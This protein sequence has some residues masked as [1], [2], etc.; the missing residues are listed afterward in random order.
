MKT[1]TASR[2]LEQLNK[3]ASALLIILSRPARLL[4]CLEFNPAEFYT[5]L[6]FEEQCLSQHNN[7]ANGG[8]GGMIEMGDYIRNKLGIAP[9]EDCGDEKNKGERLSPE[10]E[11]KP[12]TGSRKVIGFSQREWDLR[13]RKTIWTLRE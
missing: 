1:K 4:E 13:S 10:D 2:D 5:R 9:V 3:V 7:K 12:A 6:E 8:G 11:E